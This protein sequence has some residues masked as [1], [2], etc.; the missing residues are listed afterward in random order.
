MTS[1]WKSIPTYEISGAPF[2]KLK[3]TGNSQKQM[4]AEWLSGNRIMIY[5]VLEKTQ[6]CD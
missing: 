4:N 2:F 6:T 3:P 1:N 5:C